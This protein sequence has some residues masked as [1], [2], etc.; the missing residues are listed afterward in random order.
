M[1]IEG[2]AKVSIQTTKGSTFTTDIWYTLGLTRERA[3]DTALEWYSVQVA[4]DL[5]NISRDGLPRR[6]Y[7]VDDR[8]NEYDW[9]GD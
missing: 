2:H 9:W 8:G 6:I 5:I 1:M 7:I 4:T 3:I